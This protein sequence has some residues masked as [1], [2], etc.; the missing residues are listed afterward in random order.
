MGMTPQDELGRMLLVVLLENGLQLST[1]KALELVEAE[2]GHSFTKEDWAEPRSTPVET[3]WGNR[4][5]WARKDLVNLG[6]IEP[7]AVSG[8]G[9]WCLSKSG[10][11][12]AES[13]A[14]SKKIQRKRAK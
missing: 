7:V 5:R 12:R 14:A 11:A 6:L 10:R 2:F 8:R 9:V 3:N 1:G 4:T 13:L